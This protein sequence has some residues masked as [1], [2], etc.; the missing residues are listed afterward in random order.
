ME[1]L[2]YSM[3]AVAPLFVL[4]IIGYYIKQK[5]ILNATFVDVFGNFAFNFAIPISLFNI[6]SRS[7]ISEN[8]NLKLATFNTLGIVAIIVVAW[9]IVP[10]FTTR[11]R[12]GS[13]IQG[14]Y[15]SN[16]AVFSLPLAT[17][18]FGAENIAPTAI[19]IAISIPIFNSVSIV[20]LSLMGKSDKER[21]SALQ[22]VLSVAKNP[23]FFATLVGI[24]FSYFDL[25]LPDLLQVSVSSL[26]ACATPIALIALGGQ[27]SFA[28]AKSNLRASAVNTLIRLIIVPG[29]LLPIFILAGFRDAELGALFIN[30][31]API[32]TST[33]VMALNFGC[34]ENL[35]GELVL[36]TTFF[37]AFTIFGWIFALKYFAYI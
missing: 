9:I 17:N 4:V 33:F 5:N 25:A 27:F 23:I 11:P 28:S 20:L 19:M 15:R 34:D 13:I 24:L 8:F 10:R 18:M 2:L 36:F 12:A 31:S 26:A 6:T 14:L 29:V 7:H 21:M 16:L 30:F 1:T 37:S 22:V 32:A 3:N 35:A